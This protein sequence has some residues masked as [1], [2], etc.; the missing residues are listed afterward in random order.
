[1]TLESRFR[2]SSKRLVNRYGRTRIY[3]HKNGDEDYDVETGT[4]TGGTT[5]Y[6]IKVM[7]VDPREKEIKSP[8]LVNR[9]VAAMLVAAIDIPFKPSVGDKIRDQYLGVD[10]VYEV[11]DVRSNDAGDEVALWR[12]ICV[13]V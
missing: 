8:N 1:M 9:K 13:Q 11:M 7:K 5:L 6:S 10:D 12:L 4:T 2:N 3:E